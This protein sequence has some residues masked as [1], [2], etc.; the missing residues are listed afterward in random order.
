[1][2]GILQDSA[3]ATLI[4]FSGLVGLAFVN[5]AEA[6]AILLALQ[7]SMER[8]AQAVS[9]LRVILF[10]QSSWLKV[11]PPWHLAGLVEEIHDIVGAY[12]SVFIT[13]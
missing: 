12:W 4:L 3:G 6:K 5:E 13:F 1:M 2:E 10:V 7:E 11:H 9:L 8:K